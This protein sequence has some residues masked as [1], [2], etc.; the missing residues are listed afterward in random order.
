MADGRRA[1]CVEG[2]QGD[3]QPLRRVH[4]GLFDGTDLSL[5]HRQHSGVGGLGLETRGGVCEDQ[6][7]FLREPKQRPQRVECVAALPASQRLQRGR[8]VGG[9]DLSEMPVGCRPLLEERPDGSEIDIEARR[10][11]GAVSVVAV[12]Q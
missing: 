1:G 6:P 9:G 8:D 3:D 11:P 7:A 10:R 12:E 4:G 2:G 5:G